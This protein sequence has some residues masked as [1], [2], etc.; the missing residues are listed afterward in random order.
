MPDCIRYF[1][2]DILNRRVL[3][4]AGSRHSRLAIV[5]HVGRRSGKTYETPILAVPLDNDL[6]IALTYWPE[7]D[8]YHNLQAMGQ[9]VLCRKG[10]SYTIEAIELVDQALALPAFSPLQRCMLRLLNIRYFARVTLMSSESEQPHHMP[11][12]YISLTKGDLS[13]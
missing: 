7:A 13:R 11:A 12:Y 9:G 6:V 10:Q 1:N 2:R 5:R 3:R 4:S 8:W